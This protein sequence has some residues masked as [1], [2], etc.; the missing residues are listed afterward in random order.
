MRL[1]DAS[2]KALDGHSRWRLVQTAWV[3][4]PQSSKEVELALFAAEYALAEEAE[5]LRLMPGMLVEASEPK[6]KFTPDIRV[7]G[8]KPLYRADLWRVYALEA[9]MPESRLELSI[10]GSG[11]TLRVEAE[12]RGFGETDDA[13]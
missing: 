9:W 7:L 6:P 8:R 2:V 12:P 5:R 13:S 3:H 10:S 1:L 11:P 4:S